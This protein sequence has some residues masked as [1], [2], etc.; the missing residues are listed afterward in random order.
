MLAPYHTHAKRRYAMSENTLADAVV[1]TVEQIEKPD[2]SAEVPPVATPLADGAEAPANAKRG[3]KRTGKA[4]KPKP[5]AKKPKAKAEGD[6]SEKRVAVDRDTFG[7]RVNTSSHAINETIRAARG[8]LTCR[9]IH[10]RTGAAGRATMGATY[11]HLSWLLER[12]HVKMKDGG[13][14]KAPPKAKKPKAKTEAEG[15]SEGGE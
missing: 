13:F 2:M 14:V 10:E 4:G 15:A 6:E 12:G 1:A 8:P 3:N 7:N 9:E 11:R 5:K